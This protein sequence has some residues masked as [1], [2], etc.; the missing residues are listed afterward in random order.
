MNS[1]TQQQSK[2]ESN[3][4]NQIKPTNRTGEFFL[5][6]TP[7]PPPPLDIFI[8]L[9]PK[10][11][12]PQEDVSNIMNALHHLIY[13]HDRSFIKQ[14]GKTRTLK[15]HI[16]KGFHYDKETYNPH[17]PKT[18]TEHITLKFIT[19]D[20]EKAHCHHAFFTRN[21]KAISSMSRI[22]YTMYPFN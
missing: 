16:V 4:M 13:R 22:E 15:I 10:L 8:T 11:H 19:D 14:Y 5:H 17:D 20:N 9:N 18:H 1:I 12:F 6:Y 21:R 7:P 3:Q 2:M